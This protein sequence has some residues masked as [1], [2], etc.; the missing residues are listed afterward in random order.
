M[1]VIINRNIEKDFKNLYKNVSLKSL[2]K[3][4]A[5]LNID[6]FTS[7]VVIGENMYVEICLGVYS[8]TISGS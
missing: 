1:H 8:L 2:N 5:I 4:I 7:T 6:H 3:Y